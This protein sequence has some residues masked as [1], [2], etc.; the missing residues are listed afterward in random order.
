MC[1]GVRVPVDSN[2]LMMEPL[3]D[4]LDSPFLWE[5]PRGTLQ[6][7]KIGERKCSATLRKGGIAGKYA[8]R[9]S[10]GVMVSLGMNIAVA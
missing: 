10:G 3:S 1:D 7:V 5:R 4:A 2:L 6:V 8:G 9:L